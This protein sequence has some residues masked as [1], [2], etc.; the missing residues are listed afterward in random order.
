[1][2]SRVWSAVLVLGFGPALAACA[3][4]SADGAEVVPQTTPMA[5]PEG[6][7]ADRQRSEAVRQALARDAEAGPLLR[8]SQGRFQICYAPG[9]AGV[10][11]EDILYL[12]PG[13]DDAQLVGRSAHLLFHLVVGGGKAT[14][15]DP[16]DPAERQA[17]AL[18]RRVAERFATK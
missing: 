15:G 3:R 11:A 7:S 12:D 5:C 1:M 16:A 8:R 9:A 17:I 2:R 10:L 6:Y 14:S 18:E 4:S 13:L